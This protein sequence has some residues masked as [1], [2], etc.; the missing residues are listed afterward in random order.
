MRNITDSNHTQEKTV[1][2]ISWK[3]EKKTNTRH[4]SKEDNKQTSKTGNNHLRL[5]Q[6]SHTNR[7]CKMWKPPSMWFIAKARQNYKNEVQDRNTVQSPVMFRLLSNVVTFTFI[8][9][10]F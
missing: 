9:K 1:R 3:Q 10:F 7:E 6:T 8:S 5:A 4:K 2:T